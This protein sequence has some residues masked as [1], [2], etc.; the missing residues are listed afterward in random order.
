MDLVSG[1]LRS[2]YP[3]ID[4]LWGSDPWLMDY[5]GKYSIMVREQFKRSLLN[6]TRQR[7]HFKRFFQDCAVMFEEAYAC[8][9]HLQKRLKI[10][11]PSFETAPCLGIAISL[12]CE[13]MMTFMMK[14]ID[15]E[16]LGP[17]LGELP[18][19]CMQM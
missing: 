3:L 15:V 8:E 1:E 10:Q 17:A 2:L 5:V 14:S 13:A 11:K 7:R 19:F 12:Y 16:L 4:K 9:E 6:E 18:H